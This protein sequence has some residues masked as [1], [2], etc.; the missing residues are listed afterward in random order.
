MQLI[1]H[2]DIPRSLRRIVRYNGWKTLTSVECFRK[3]SESPIE[4]KRSRRT[5]RW[6][7]FMVQPTRKSTFG[8]SRRSGES[9]RANFRIVRKIRDI[10]RL[11]WMIKLMAAAKC[12]VAFTAKTPC[13]I[14]MQR[15]IH[16]GTVSSTLNPTIYCHIVWRLLSIFND[17]RCH[18]L[19]SGHNVDLSFLTTDS[20]RLGMINIESY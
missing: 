9:S 5:Y 12:T 18:G 14:Y 4:R 16:C 6:K 8:M 17:F 7:R 3:E 10:P 13:W 11:Q 19:M 1:Q 15:K 20:S 2:N